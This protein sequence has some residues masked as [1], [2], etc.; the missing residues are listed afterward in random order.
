MMVN[1]I[2]LKWLKEILRNLRKIFNQLTIDYYK[3]DRNKE[4]QKNHKFNFFIIKNYEQCTVS[5]IEMQKK[6][7]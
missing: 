7:N 4:N 2:Q 5:A 1:Q 3:K 6:S